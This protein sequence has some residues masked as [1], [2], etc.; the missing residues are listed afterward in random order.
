MF[1]AIFSIICIL[2]LAW[3]FRKGTIGTRF[4]HNCGCTPNIDHLKWKETSDAPPKGVRDEKL[5]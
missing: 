4:E 1:G 2:V 3:L 5:W